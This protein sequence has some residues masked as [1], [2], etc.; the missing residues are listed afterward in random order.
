MK[1]IV[2]INNSKCIKCMECIKYCPTNV[3]KLENNLIKANEEK[4]IYCKG[5]EV[6]CP[7][8]AIKLIALNENIEVIKVKTLITEKQGK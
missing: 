6:L 5:C 7:T 3:F 4:C 1:V 8:K 2:K